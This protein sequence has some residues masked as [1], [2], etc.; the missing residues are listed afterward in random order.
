[1]RTILFLRP[2]E[3]ET[4]LRRTTLGPF[5]FCPEQNTS[6][7]TAWFSR[8]H[9]LSNTVTRTQHS[10][11]SK[12]QQCEYRSWSNLPRATPRK[13]THRP[14]HAH[15]MNTGNTAPLISQ[16]KRRSAVVANGS[17]FLEPLH[18]ADW[19]GQDSD[20]I[21]VALTPLC[22]GTRTLHEE[23]H[24]SV[25][26]RLFGLCTRSKFGAR[27]QAL[28]TTHWLAAV[29]VHVIVCRY[30]SSW[31]PWKLRALLR[32][33]LIGYLSGCSSQNALQ[34][35]NCRDW[36]RFQDPL[37][38]HSSYGQVG[39]PSNPDLWR[40]RPNAF[41][42]FTKDHRTWPSRMWGARFHASSQGFDT[43]FDGLHGSV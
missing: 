2:S 17:G 7:F 8:H 27:G 31:L 34:W 25:G 29:A 20:R 16:V 1:M 42:T 35:V 6:S 38:R 23:A 24:S 21:R 40:K 22:F 37:C 41:R 26:L 18:K 28:N 3:Y 36:T 32:G 10:H 12:G 13:H 4:F 5:N 39:S 30:R 43:A 33:I 15:Y 9:S 19:H 14:Q 11:K